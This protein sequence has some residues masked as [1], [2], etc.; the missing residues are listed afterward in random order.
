MT[1]FTASFWNPPPLQY[2]NTYMNVLFAGPWT[3]ITQNFSQLKWKR[4]LK[5]RCVIGF[6]ACNCTV[7]L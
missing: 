5:V 6:L 2:F 1:E 7:L 3:S 4:C